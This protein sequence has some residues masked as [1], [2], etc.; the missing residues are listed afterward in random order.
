MLQSLKYCYICTQSKYQSVTEQSTL[1]SEN[2][3]ESIPWLVLGAKSI[4]VLLRFVNLQLQSS[5]SSDDA[6]HVQWFTVMML[7][8]FKCL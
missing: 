8:M 6:F 5:K 4:F 3:A 2:S 7:F 1:A